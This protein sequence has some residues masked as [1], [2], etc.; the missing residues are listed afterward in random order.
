ME[1][2]I[3]GKYQGRT[4]EI[5]TAP[6]EQEADRLVQE[7]RMA[8]GTSWLVWKGRKRNGEETTEGSDV[9][10]RTVG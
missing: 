6:D 8:F 7:Y 10:L 2:K 5:D 1:I 9:R 3:W 4:E